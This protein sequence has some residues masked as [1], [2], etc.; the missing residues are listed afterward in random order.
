MV[1]VFDKWTP[2]EELVK[3]PGS[4]GKRI[5]NPT[6]CMI[7]NEINGDYSI[8]LHQPITPDDDS[9]QYLKPYDILR[10]TSGQ[11]FL[12]DYHQ[13]KLV[14]GV[15]T[16]IVKGKHI[17]YYLNHKC[18]YNIDTHGKGPDGRGLECWMILDELFRNAHIS[19]TDDL[20]EYRFTRS[21]DIGELNHYQAHGITIAKG[22][23]DVCDIWGGYLYRDNFNF[24]VRGVMQGAKYNAF[25]AEHGWD[26][27]D[28]VET[29]DYSTDYTEIRVDDNLGTQPYENSVVPVKG[30]RFQFQRSRYF[31][32]SYE[33]DS[34]LWND[35]PK[36]FNGTGPSTSYEI[37]IPSLTDTTRE[38][39]W[40]DLE[41]VKPGDVGTV[42]SAVLG[43]TT[44]DQMVVSVDFNEL[45]QKNERVKIQGFRHSDSLHP[46][47]YD[48]FING[49]MDAKT[50]R[51]ANLERK[52]GYFE[53]IE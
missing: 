14:N 7:H 26:V 24:T 20:I 46:G 4:C 48:Q 38:K 39:G 34:N 37:V 45:T 25:H 2:Q 12:I 19:Y 32:L 52:A 18:T 41:T 43:F 42:K 15:P 30:G 35:A 53:Y 6:Y 36:M 1:C 40:S 23:F 17:F 9:Y 5:L 22:V 50:R 51:I 31:S 8:E 29:I 49:A 27:T 16:L 47:R 13:K 33:Q 3:R 11:L 28:I 10:V 21:A 44:T